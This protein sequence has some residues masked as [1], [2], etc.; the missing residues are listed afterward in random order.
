MHIG[1]NLINTFYNAYAPGKF[2][3]IKS[4]AGKVRYRKVLI[5][6]LFWTILFSCKPSEPI[7]IGFVAGTSGRVADMGIAGRDAAQLAV[8]Q[9][10]NAGGILGRK[11]QLIIKNDEQ[12]S[13]PDKLCFYVKLNS[14]NNLIIPKP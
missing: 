4:R 11:V 3:R 1:A 8:D 13:V 12:Q 2:M 14:L 6:L 7:R 5:C 9:R 10:N